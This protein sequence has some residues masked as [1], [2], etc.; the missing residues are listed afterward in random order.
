M[1]T[2]NRED[3][4]LWEKL[5]TIRVQGCVCVSDKLAA[6]GSGE[7]LLTPC[8]VQ[9]LLHDSVLIPA[10]GLKL[11]A[12]GTS[13]ADMDADRFRSQASLPSPTWIF[14]APINLLFF[15]FVC[16]CFFVLFCFVFHQFA[17]D[18]EPISRPCL[19]L[20]P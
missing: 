15:L 18:F 7:E 20:I 13:Q 5:H 17:F 8:P 11:S 19:H 10:E 12:E 2:G 6:E 4:I 1:C 3:V 9:S 14:S 16:F